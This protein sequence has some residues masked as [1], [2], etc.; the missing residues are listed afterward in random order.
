VQQRVRRALFG[1]GAIALVSTACASGEEPDELETEGDFAHTD[2]EASSAGEAS[3]GSDSDSDDASG[4]GDTDPAPGCTPEGTARGRLYL[5][6]NASDQSLYAGGFEAGVDTPVAGAT[7]RLASGAGF[8]ETV[9]CDDGRYGFPDLDDGIYVLLPEPVADGCSLRNCPRR[10]PAALEEGALNLLTI[11]DSVPVEGHPVTFPRRVADLFSAVVEVG[12]GN[13]AVSGSV[14]SEWLPGQPYFES[15]LRPALDQADVVVISLGGNDVLRFI[16]TVDFTDLTA[17]LAGAN[18]TV[19]QIVANV[20]AIA[21]EIR[22]VEPDIDVVFCLYVDYSL[23][24]NTSPWSS[25][26]FLPAGV[27]TS[28]L[29]RA[30]DQIT[31][32]DDFVLVDLL[33][34]S[35]DLPMPLDDYLVD[36]LHFNDAGHT[37]YAYEVFRALGG[38]IVGDLP[39]PTDRPFDNERSFGFVP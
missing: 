20:R 7:V 13:V 8:T 26:A 29:E 5:D 22:Q 3:S 31:P 24:T 37:L 39:L 30:R 6:E 23:A 16:S 32:D 1:W 35:Q 11:G 15:R 9:T 21:G 18:A 34:V 10:L 33:E 12:N 36:S 17:A 2:G 4:G 27:V 19:D 25:T 38:V 14:S 28:L